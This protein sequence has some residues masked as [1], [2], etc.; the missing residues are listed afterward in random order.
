MPNNTLNKLIDAALN[1]IVEREGNDD[2]ICEQMPPEYCE[3]HC[4]NLNKKCVKEFLI[5]HY[6]P[7]K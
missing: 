7:K 3:T 2:F 1:F 6:E 5:N 4:N